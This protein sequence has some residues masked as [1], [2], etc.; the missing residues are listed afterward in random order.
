MASFLTDRPYDGGKKPLPPKRLPPGQAGKGKQGTGSPWGLSAGDV[1][2]F[3]FRRKVLTVS[4]SNVASAQFIA[5][6]NK[7]I[8][9][10]LDDGKPGQHYKYDGVTEQEALS[11]AN[12]GSKGVWTWTVLRVRGSKT[13]HRKPF[14]LVGG[15]EP[16]L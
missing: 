7:L 2:A 11:F 5:G 10:Y 1:E 12:A 4:S 6:Q 15:F 3:L 8:V 14:S 13:A 9:Q 16:E